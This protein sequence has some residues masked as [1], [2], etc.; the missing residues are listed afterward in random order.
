MSKSYKQFCFEYTKLYI[1]YAVKNLNISSILVK[2]L[3]VFIYVCVC[4]FTYKYICLCVYMYQCIYNMD[5]FASGPFGDVSFM[6]IVA[7][8]VSIVYKS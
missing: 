3:L 7:G 4:I 8:L 6:S 5:H 1:I 2:N